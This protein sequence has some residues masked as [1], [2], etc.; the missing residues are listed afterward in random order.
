M[1]AH[2]GWLFVVIGLAIAMLVSFAIPR[3]ANRTRTRLPR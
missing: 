3:A 1:L 2:H